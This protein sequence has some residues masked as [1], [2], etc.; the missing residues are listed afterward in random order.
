MFQPE[1]WV[2]FIIVLVI[3]LFVLTGGADLGAGVW[4]WG[5]IG[6]HKK[7]QREIILKALEPIWGANHLWLIAAAVLFL[8]AFPKAFSAVTFALR[9]PIII[10]VT[11]IAFRGIAFVFL[12][13]RK[14][15]KG[16]DLAW[17]SVFALSSL[18]T[19]FAMGTIVGSVFSGNIRVE[20][21]KGEVFTDFVSPWFSFFPLSVGMLALFLFSFLGA[22]YL[23]FETPEPHLKKGFRLKAIFSGLLLGWMTLVCFS[24]SEGGAYGIKPAQVEKIWPVVYFFISS[25]AAI[26]ALMSLI[27]KRDKTGR[28]LAWAQT[29]LIIVGWAIS[30]Y[31]HLIVPDLTLANAAAPPSLLI[32]LL[33]IAGLGLSVLFP[34]F[35]YLYWVSKGSQLSLRK[36]SDSQKP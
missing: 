35:F 30:Q 28:F 5:T 29:I 12:N 15:S 10:M 7:S 31:P 18:V 2:A 11:G 6:S 23:V 3:T 25:F 17:S 33:V 9:I 34:A 22:T 8:A 36:N 13:Y 26:G 16:A 24:F 27:I 19:P 20:S 14:N 4:A 1:F 21:L 32:P